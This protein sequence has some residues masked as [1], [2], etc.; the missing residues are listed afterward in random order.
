MIVLTIHRDDYDE[1]D[2][3]C[4]LQGISYTPMFSGFMISTY[5]VE[6]EWESILLRLRFKAR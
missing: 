6:H 2:D 1:F 5:A 3:F 4:S